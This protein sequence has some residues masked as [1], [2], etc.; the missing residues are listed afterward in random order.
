MARRQLTGEREESLVLLHPLWPHPYNRVTLRARVSRCITT[1][2]PANEWNGQGATRY[3]TPC[4]SRSSRRHRWLLDQPHRS[5]GAQPPPCAHSKRLGG[6]GW[7]RHGSERCRQ[8][9]SP[10]GIGR[11]HNGHCGWHSAARQKTRHLGLGW[12]ISGKPPSL[13][14]CKM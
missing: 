3:P 1:H 4:A 2:L 8:L 13:A 14:P 10:G 11:R 5:A 6:E 12:A 9:R 7:P